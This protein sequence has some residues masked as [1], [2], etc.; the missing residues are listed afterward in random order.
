MKADYTDTYTTT[1]R[2]ARC[3][4]APDLFRLIPETRPVPATAAG[5]ACQ[6]IRTSSRRRLY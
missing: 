5:L 4:T 2:N 3:M 6:A 1:V